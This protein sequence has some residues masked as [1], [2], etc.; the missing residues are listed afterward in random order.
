MTKK[1]REVISIALVAIL[2]LGGSNLLLSS[3]ISPMIRDKVYEVE[4]EVKEILDRW[5][6][7]E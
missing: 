5:K 7:E 4:E 6:M 1:D 3:R 2:H